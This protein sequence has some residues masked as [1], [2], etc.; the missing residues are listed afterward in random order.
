[1]FRAGAVMRKPD[2][3]RAADAERCWQ[4]IG[5]GLYVDVNATLEAA[6][7]VFDRA[8]VTFLPVVSLTGENSAPELRGALFHVDALKAYNR[9]LAAT[10]AE[11]HS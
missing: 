4:M 1:M 3:A 11:E 10:A 2:H 9:A 5:E 8:G 6:M 7:P